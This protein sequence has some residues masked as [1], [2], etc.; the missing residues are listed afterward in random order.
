MGIRETEDPVELRT[1]RGQSR[2]QMYP[3][4]RKVDKKTGNGRQPEST[5]PT[6]G[7]NDFNEPTDEG[8]ECAERALRFLR[9]T[10]EKI[11]GGCR[12]AGSGAGWLR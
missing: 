4:G 8:N 1:S 2:T 9:T 3:R 5:R 7:R 11:T 10:R 12:R 6:D